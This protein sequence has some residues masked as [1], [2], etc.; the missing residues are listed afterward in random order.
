VSSIVGSKTEEQCRNF[1][2][3]FKRKYGPNVF[4][5]EDAR[6]SPV[7]TTVTT[8]STTTTPILQ[9]LPTKQTSTPMPLVSSNPAS[10]SA[11]PV[12]VPVSVPAQVQKP[13]AIPQSA[14]AVIPASASIPAL[15]S[16]QSTPTVSSPAKP[17]TSLALPPVAIAT[18]AIT[19]P[20]AT[21]ASRMAPV[22]TT[23][24]TVPVPGPSPPSE[25]AVLSGRTDLKAEEE[26]AAAALVDMFQMGANTTPREE[27]NK[28]LALPSRSRTPSASI[29]EES[30]TSTVSPTSS[31]QKRR[32][33][34]TSSSKMDNLSEDG[35]EWTDPDYGVKSSGRKLGR[36]T[37]VIDSKKP[38]NSSYWSVSER[39]DFQKYLELYG[40]D[41]EKLSSAM[42]TKTVIQVRNFY[43]NNEEKMKLR[44]IV[45]R[46]EA[47]AKETSP[48]EKSNAAHFQALQN[49]PFPAPISKQA[50]SSSP[51][52]SQAP[53]Q[54]KSVSS[55][56]T[57]N[58]VDFYPPPQAAERREVYP[59]AAP[60]PPP[61][62]PPSR[63][64]VSPRLAVVSAPE[65][66]PSA[67][68]KVADLLNNDD[69]A[70]PNQNSWET[71]FGS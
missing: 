16:V 5:E 35:S 39:N 21:P 11:A 32:R 62:H 12:S 65:P 29:L 38:T 3:N 43:S 40:R 37:S 56:Y 47:R 26:D 53:K 15:T 27:L 60:P 24:P 67:V 55:P 20:V 17:P 64:Y 66:V 71:W 69:P 50:S 51:P 4:N 25:V 6:R 68:T 2:H 33:A 10:S 63:P 18:S 48:L 28:P 58:R 70:E 61:T 34:R 36:T 46:H 45:E 7:N 23:A 19:A 42:K 31:I 8:A 22:A 13:V 59:T 9:Q 57:M 52:P 54:A 1:Y 41:W 44:E 49:F 30:H 14:R